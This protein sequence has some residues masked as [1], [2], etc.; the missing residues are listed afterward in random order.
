MP[1]RHMFLLATV[2]APTVL[3]L[4]YAPCGLLAV[5]LCGGLVAV[6]LST[7]LRQPQ[8]VRQAVTQQTQ[9]LLRAQAALQQQLTAYAQAHE[10]LRLAK[11]AAEWANRAKDVFLVNISH[12]LRMPLNAIVGYSEML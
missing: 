3:S 11:E 2:L 12:E 6:L 4:A 10:A 1:A 5:G 7:L 9:A 8:Q